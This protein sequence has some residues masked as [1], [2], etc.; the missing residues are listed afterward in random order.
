MTETNG[1]NGHPS[2]PPPAPPPQREEPAPR[3][4]TRHL[5]VDVRDGNCVLESVEPTIGEVVDW[6]AERCD[7]STVSSLFASSE[8]RRNG[9]V[10]GALEPIRLTG[11]DR[12]DTTSEAG[13]GKA[14]PTCADGAHEWDRT[15]LFCDRCPAIMPLDRNADTTSEAFDRAFAEG[16]EKAGGKMPS[17]WIEAYIEERH[18]FGNLKDTAQRAHAVAAACVQYLDEQWRERGGR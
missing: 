18:G 13:L 1:T 9:A 17:E 4:P 16:G 11:P 14:L 12:N 3:E 8:L 10:P 7:P 5:V 2:S 6:L 15:G